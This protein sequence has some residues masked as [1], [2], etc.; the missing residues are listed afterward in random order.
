MTNEQPQESQLLKDQIISM[1][2]TCF[3]PEIPANIYELGMVY[4]ID[5]DDQ[6][7]VKIK[8][9]LTSPNCPAIE[10]LPQDIQNKINSIPG[11]NKTEIELVWDPP[12]TPE[13]MSEEA[14]LQLNMF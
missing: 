2:K 14:K 7:N 1:L 6:K 9:T 4:N 11:I 12:W 13:K 8:M 3:D 10:S 5:I